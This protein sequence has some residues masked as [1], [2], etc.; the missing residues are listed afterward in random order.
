[1]EH[2]AW[3][4]IMG[5]ESYLQD[6]VRNEPL[7]TP[8]ICQS[9]NAEVWKLLEP[10]LCGGPASLIERTCKLREFH[11]IMYIDLQDHPVYPMIQSIFKSE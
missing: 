9:T 10:P 1:M 7:I 2:F 4:I 3:S 11:S 5:P 8:N 6:Y